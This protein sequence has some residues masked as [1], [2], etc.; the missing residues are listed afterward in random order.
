MPLTFGVYNVQ[1]FK[2]VIYISDDCMSESNLHYFRKRKCN[3][4]SK[5]TKQWLRGEG[6]QTAFHRHNFQL[7]QARSWYWT[8]DLGSESPVSYHY[9]FAGVKNGQEYIYM[10]LFPNEI[11]CNEQHIAEKL[12]WS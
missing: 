11:E 3:T 1:G 5:A 10:A 12:E 2:E 8:H 9:I 7:T 6:D 4:D